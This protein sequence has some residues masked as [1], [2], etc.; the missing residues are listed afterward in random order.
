MNA[1]SD[2]EYIDT[3]VS[4]LRM[5]MDA[6][7]AQ[8]RSQ[9]DAATAKAVLHL[10]TW[11]AGIFIASVAINVALASLII[12]L[13]Q[14]EYAVAPGAAAHAAATPAII[15]QWLPQGAAV[16]PAVPPPAGQP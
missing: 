7:F 1:N 2:R 6:G 10:V 16:L 11:M 5:V 14:R 12:S 15:I 3:K 9:A 13:I 4:D 8:S